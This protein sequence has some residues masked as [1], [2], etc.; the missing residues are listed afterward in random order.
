MFVAMFPQSAVFAES[1]SGD[2]TIAASVSFNNINIATTQKNA[3]TLSGDNDATF[4]F[5]G[6]NIL[7][8]ANS[9]IET[10]K[11]DLKIKSENEGKLRISN[12]TYAISSSSA[13]SGALLEFAGNAH[14]EIEDCTSHMI[15][16]PTRPISFSGA[17]VVDI[18]SNASTSKWAIYGAGLTFSGGSFS[19]NCDA[20]SGTSYA[21]CC[22]GKNKDI[23]ISGTTDIHI[24]KAR[25]GIH[26]D[27]GNV[28]ITD[29]AKIRMYDGGD[30]NRTGGLLMG[31]AISNTEGQ[32][33]C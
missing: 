31:N 10:N 30:S 4:D 17:P 11:T 1:N 19:I 24:K 25:R 20:A 28:T 27:G 21:I 13:E 2:F 14:I 12:S 23:R 33:D 16:Y 7:S 6:I 5:S 22:S 26:T 8:A 15:Y 9:G 18:K 29:E 32:I 3:V